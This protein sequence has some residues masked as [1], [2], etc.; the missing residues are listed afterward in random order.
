MLEGEEEAEDTVKKLINLTEDIELDVKQYSLKSFRTKGNQG[1]NDF[2]MNKRRR[3][4]EDV[5]G[6]SGTGGAGGVDAA[7]CAEL[8]AHGY[9]VKPQAKDIVDPCG[10]YILETFYRVWQPLYTYTPR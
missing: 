3:F 4:D 7:D 1:A 6:G 2:T 9:E 8:R 10:K 5:G